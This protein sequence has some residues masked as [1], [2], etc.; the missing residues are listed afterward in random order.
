MLLPLITEILGDLERNG[1]AGAASSFSPDLLVLNGAGDFT[2]G[3]PRGDNGL[4]G[5][6]LVVDQYG[7]TVP[8]GGGAL[9]GKD[10]HKIDKCGPLRARQLAKTL[11]RAGADSADVTLPW[12]P[13]ADAPPSVMAVT[14]RGGA[15]Q[16]V[17]EGQLP[18][19]EWFSIARIVSDLELL[20]IDWEE[21][22]LDGYFHDFN[23]RWER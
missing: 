17:P 7:P 3:G 15:R 8:I 11:V 16:R 20:H 4:S 9:S 2:V 23:A 5:K 12:A 21:Q 22:V 13:G 19:P 1:L 6:K 18:P 10:P 14:T